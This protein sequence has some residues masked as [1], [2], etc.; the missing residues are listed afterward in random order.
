MVMEVVWLLSVFVFDVEFKFCEKEKTISAGSSSK[1]THIDPGAQ[2]TL[3]ISFTG[4]ASENTHQCQC[5][6]HI[7]VRHAITTLKNLPVKTLVR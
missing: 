4:S 2:T 7:L 3:I 1:K 6:I 5:K